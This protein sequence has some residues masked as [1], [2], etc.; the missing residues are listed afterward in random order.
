M[1]SDLPRDS[2]QTT[3]LQSVTATPKKL[4][5]FGNNMGLELLK[6]FRRRKSKCHI[7]DILNLKSTL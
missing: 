7:H 6:Y 2:T 5:D 4:S 1:I 3:P